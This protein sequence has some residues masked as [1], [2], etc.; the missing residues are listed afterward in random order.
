MH[1]L[2]IAMSFYV[3]LPCCDPQAFFFSGSHPLLMWNPPQYAAN[4]IDF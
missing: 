2:T 4:T 3:Q 1:A